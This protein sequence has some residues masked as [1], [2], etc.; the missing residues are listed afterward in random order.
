MEIQNILAANLRKLRRAKTF[1]QE[2]R[3]HRA[4]V[5]RTHIRSIE[6][7]VNAPSIDIVERLA[8]QLDAE[9]ADLLKR[10]IAPGQEKRKPASRIHPKR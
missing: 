6:R 8:R 9:A 3:A 5:D 10:P 1:S 7:A 4:K 2:E